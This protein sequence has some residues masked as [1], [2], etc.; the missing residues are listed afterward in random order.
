MKKRLLIILPLFLILLV[1]T[2]CEITKRDAKPL[3][4]GVKD[5]TIEKGSVFL[6]LEGVSVTD[7][8]DGDIDLSLITVDAR[9]VNVN[10]VGTYIVTYSVTDSY[11][12]TT[13]VKRSVTVVFTDTISPVLY[14]ANDCEII[15]G[16]EN[17]TPLLNVSANDNIDGEIDS[18]I[19]CTGSVD[20]WV[21]GEYELNYEVSD[22]AGNKAEAVRTV[23]VGFGDFKF[24]EVN[25][26]NSELNNRE[27][28][29]EDVEK[30]ITVSHL[31]GG[32]IHDEVA[33][34]AL[35]KLVIKASSTVDKAL[36]IDITNATTSSEELILTSDVLEF[37]KYFRLSEEL[38][39][40]ELILTFA[41]GDGIVTIHEA[42]LYLASVFDDVAP[43]IEIINNTEVYVPVGFSEAAVKTELLKGVTAYDN[44]DGNLTSKLFVDLSLVDLYD[45]NTYIVTISVEDTFKNV[46]S[47]ERTLVVAKARNSGIISD[48]GFD[49]STNTQFKLST[50]GGGNVKMAAVDGNLVVTI[51]SAGGWSSA[52]SP[53]LSG[54]TTDQL[55]AGFYYLFQMDIKGTKERRMA[56]RAG[57]ELYDSPWI[58]DFG[59][60]E[61]KFNITTEWTTVYYVFYVH[62]SKSAVGSKNVK[63]EI[64]LGSIDWND[65]ESGN[66]IYIDNAQFYK[67]TNINESPVITQMSDIQTTYPQGSPLPDFKTFIT[68]YDLED[69]EILITDDMIDLGDF[70]INLSGTYDIIYTVT[71]KDNA[72]TTH[73][74]RITI[75]ETIDTI[76]PVITI[77]EFALAYINSLLPVKQGYDLTSVIASLAEYI[78]IVDDVDGNISFN[79]NMIDFNGLNPNNPQP[80][81]YD[82]KISTKDS[83]GN[84][85]N[86]LVIVIT[87]SDSEAPKLIGATNMLLYLGDT[88]NPLVG[89]V[90]YDNYD[91]VIPLTRSHISGLD[92]FLDEN[93]NVVE[94]GDFQ[95]TYEVEDAAGNKEIKTV[96]FT[97][98]QAAPDF[99][100]DADINLIS[101]ISWLS[102]GGSGSTLSQSEGFATV[103]YKSSGVGYASGV[104]LKCDANIKL[105]AG[106]TFKLIIEAEIEVPRDILIYF[107]DSTGQKITGFES[108]SDYNKHRVGLVGGGH[109]YEYVFTV[110]NTSVGS[111]T[112]EIDLDYEETLANATVAQQIVFKQIKLISTDGVLGS[113]NDQLPPVIMVENFESFVDN[114]TFQ[115]S[116]SDAIVGFRVGSGAFIKS[117]GTLINSEGNKLI[118]QNVQYLN[119]STCGIR[120]KVSKLTIPSNIHYLA[121]WMQTTANLVEINQIQS[122]IYDA[123]GNYSD[124]SSSLIGDKTKLNEGTFVYIP[125]NSLKDNTAQVS[126]V[127]NIKGTASGKLYFDDIL[128]VKEIIT[129]FGYEMLENFESYA[130]NDEFQTATNDTVVG[131]RVGKA[132]FLKTNGELIIDDENQYVQQNFAYIDMSVSGIRIRV[133]KESIPV[134]VKYLAIWMQASNITNVNR[135]QAFIYNS[136]NKNTEITS[137]LIGSINDLV[138]GMYIYIPVSALKDDTVELALLVNVNPNASGTLII[139]NIS[140]VK[141]FY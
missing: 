68:A 61:P 49:N 120:I 114:D 39:D 72:K 27:I 13:K 141:K 37:V 5:I 56:I 104:H 4:H 139:D 31:N 119:G 121:I 48:P 93:N 98:E 122:F 128:Y 105:V 9:S 8:E 140:L 24:S 124:I 3:F 53:Y 67:L 89:V 18:A 65:N 108:A 74:I 38:I 95:V 6:P 91:G 127:I 123:S 129:S 76:G 26:L 30:V 78:T 50:G 46:S 19:L 2:S 63:F 87:V 35:A 85:S 11:G 103:N 16:D 115:A 117:N 62:A 132:P 58:E 10:V 83:T 21:P 135:F 57:L 90:A 136:S 29:V 64:H 23:T 45:A 60:R 96:L 55:Q 106:E 1:M 130:S 25:I 12:N 94:V 134:G 22:N 133:T 17:F 126:L 51:T 42:E 131:F 125:V 15:I 88:Y 75:T 92:S 99:Y 54:I 7:K 14:G 40:D 43:V 138:D 81:S 82:V 80:G 70:D 110:Q 101:K 86:E 33:N 113:S 34:F 84:E 116:T 73:T 59:V 36:N 66:T 107:V 97:V 20:I 102:S 112:F 77:S 52:D 100:D 44:M 69:G 32:Q 111:C 28:I 109:I 79:E 137:S 71:D 41:S 118:E 47:I